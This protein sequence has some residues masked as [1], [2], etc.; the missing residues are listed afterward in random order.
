MPKAF[1]LMALTFVINAW[2]ILPVEMNEISKEATPENLGTKC[3]PTL[4]HWTEILTTLIKRPQNKISQ[5]EETLK[6]SFLLR[7][8]IHERLGFMP[9]ECKK[10]TQGVFTK[11]RE[12]EDLVGAASYPQFKISDIDYTKVSAP[13]LDHKGYAPY[14]LNP[15]FEKFTFED[16]DIMITK[17]ISTISSTIST[18]TDF[19]SPFSHIA[20]IHLDPKSNKIETIESYV[21]KGVSFFSIIDAMK[22]ENARILILRPKD[23]DL[24]KKAAAYIRNRVQNEVLKG[25]YI[26]YDYQMNFDQNQ[27]LSCEEVAFDAFKTASGGSFTIPEAPSFIKFKNGGLTSKVGMRPGKMMM[28]ADMEVDSRFDIVLD[29]TDYSIIRDSWRKDTMMN[30]AIHLNDAG[31]YDLPENYKTR[32]VPYIWKLRTVPYLWPMASKLSGIPVDYT[33]DVPANSIATLVSFKE[34]EANHLHELQKFD[35]EFFKTYKYWPNRLSLIEKMN[36]S[37]H[38]FKK[39]K[40]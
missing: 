10:L 36:Q 28:P 14:Q 5:S 12:F 22:N 13:V 8:K 2:G 34:I 19:S 37:I 26:P 40:D 35:E 4:N 25:T 9:V 18:F 16:G 7:L 31:F 29:W 1:I 33:P 23:R 17:G 30:V 27:T 32:L 38:P 15:K 21:G 11:L 6:E 3:I 24:A 20:F 39:F